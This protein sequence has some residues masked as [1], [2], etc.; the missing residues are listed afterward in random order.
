METTFLELKWALCTGP[1]LT[2]PNFSKLFVLQTDTSQVGVRA[3][4]SQIQDCTEHPIMFISRKLLKHERNY[5]T[6][7]KEGLA[8]KW[9]LQKLQYYLLGWEF[10]FGH[11]SCTPKVDGDQS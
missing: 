7:E 3:V 11:Q 6:V 2:T 4:L 10:V 5:A 8:I 9:A 1:V